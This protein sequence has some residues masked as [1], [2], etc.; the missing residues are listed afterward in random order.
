MPSREV[1]QLDQVLHGYSDGHRELQSSV[2]LPPKT[3][4]ILQINSDLS[5][6]SITRGFEAYLTGYPLPEINSYA[7][8]KTWYAP[9][10]PR[11]GCVWTHSLI[12]NNTDLAHIPDLALVCQLFLRPSSKSDWRKYHRPIECSPSKLSKNEFAPAAKN[13]RS[14]STELLCALYEFWDSPIFVA[15]S[16]SQEYETI[17]VAIWSQQWPRMRRSFKFCTGSLSNRKFDGI[18]FD[19]QIVPSTLIPAIEREAPTGNIIRA[20]IRGSA[21]VDRDDPCDLHANA[22]LQAATGDLEVRS[23][24]RDFLWRFG[25]DQPDD[26]SAFRRLVEIYNCVLRANNGT[27]SLQDLLFLVGSDFPQSNEAVHL[28]QALFGGNEF[29]KEFLRVNASESELLS[30]LT[31]TTSHSAFD[32]SS[33]SIRNRAKGLYEE[34]REKANRLALN[35]LIQEITPFGEEYLTGVCEVISVEDALS[36]TTHH[37]GLLPLIV[38]SNPKLLT[39]PSIWKGSIDLQ[40][41]IFDVVTRDPASTKFLTSLIPILLEVGT[42]S[43][44]DEIEG[45]LDSDLAVRAILEWFNSRSSD[46]FQV[47]TPKWQRILSNHPRHVL[48]WILQTRNNGANLRTLALAARSLDPH[49]LGV[50][51]ADAGMW[52]DLARKASDL[53]EPVRIQTMSF[54]LALG[55]NNP[56]PNGAQ[57]VSHSFPFVHD[58]ARRNRLDYA[59]WRVLQT[60][61]PSVSFWRSWDKCE[62][63]RYALIDRFIRFEWPE[64]DFL[65]AVSDPD[66]F[67]RTLESC[68]ETS[69]GRKF[70]RR[71]IRMTQRNSIAATDEQKRVLTALN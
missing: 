3:A 56:P 28:K 44:A 5:G 46:D 34:N 29:Q 43:L 33:L 11:P 21:R 53:E 45:R 50:V 32:P 1:F 30:G 42:D 16:S 20:S 67:H 24:L 49:D 15:A 35:I 62:R 61:A 7:F 2:K 57:I 22:W 52:L 37:P 66:T 65:R 23:P 8:A 58:A 14:L 18:P 13:L 63:L 17:A 9:E 39:E 4:H 64:E 59:D 51:Q 27:G 12:I 38:Q 68:N 25:S 48:D 54:L 10:M 6:S 36:L 70:L 41:E 26:R 71:I 40:R 55:F 31:T 60:Q 19:L 69:R 47:V